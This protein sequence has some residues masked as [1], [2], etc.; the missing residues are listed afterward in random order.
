MVIIGQNTLREKLRIDVMT[1]L[2]ASVLKAHK[3]EDRSGMEIT[4]GAVDEPNADAVLQAAM[5]VMAFGPGGNEPGEVDN[6]VTM[7]RLS[8]QPMMFQ[9]SEVETQDRVSAL[10][11]A[12]DDAVDHGLPPECAKMLRDIAFRTHLGVFRR[13]LLGDPPARVEPTVRL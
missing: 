2:K 3:R 12:V 4:A 10:E 5:V 9:D 11:T 8:Q 13:V 7:T 6:D 1:E